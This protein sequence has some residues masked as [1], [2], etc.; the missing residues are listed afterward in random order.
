M[1]VELIAEL[2]KTRDWLAGAVIDGLIHKMPD[3][4]LE[5]MEH[6]V[7]VTR[8]LQELEKTGTPGIKI[9]QN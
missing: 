9:G 7:T 5:V 2:Q 3:C 4:S 8:A 6:L 1:N